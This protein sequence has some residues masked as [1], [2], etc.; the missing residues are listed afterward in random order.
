MS[1]QKQEQCWTKDSWQMKQER[2][3]VARS[4]A[5]CSQLPMFSG[6]M[7]RAVK[8]SSQSRKKSGFLSAR[9]GRE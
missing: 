1:W 2:E 8:S 3:E 4:L 5:I 6:R 9:E 7:E